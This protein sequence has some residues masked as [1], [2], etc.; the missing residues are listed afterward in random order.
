MPTQVVFKAIT[1]PWSALRAYVYSLTDFTL[2]APAFP[3][4]DLPDNVLL[5]VAELL[6]PSYRSELRATSRR[7]RQLANLATSSATVRS[8]I[9]ASCLSSRVLTVLV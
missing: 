2:P 8:A 1:N 5:R 7:C 4:F 3:L 9:P 6:P